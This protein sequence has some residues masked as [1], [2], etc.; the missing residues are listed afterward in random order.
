MSAPPRR[1]GLRSAL[2]RIGPFCSARYD[3][4]ASLTA[5]QNGSY[6]RAGRKPAPVTV[7]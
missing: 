5:A 7:R 3:G 4:H 6:L 2:S 1:S